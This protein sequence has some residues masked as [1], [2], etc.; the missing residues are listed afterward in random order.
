MK[1]NKKVSQQHHV[2]VTFQGVSDATALA[3]AKLGASTRMIRQVTGLSE[4]QVIYRLS[5]AKRVEGHQHGYRV[6]WRN[7]ESA[8]FKQVADDMMKVMVRDIQRS[9][10]QQ[11]IHPQP[12]NQ[13]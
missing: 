2:L 3:Y 5:K 9:L 11:I 8:E 10:P 12:G 7:G 1:Q 4:S 6:A 13:Q